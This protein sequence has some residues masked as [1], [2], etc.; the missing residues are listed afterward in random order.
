MAPSAYHFVNMQ[1]NQIRMTTAVVLSRSPKQL[2]NK[3]QDTRNGPLFRLSISIRRTNCEIIHNQPQRYN[4]FPSPNTLSSPFLLQRL[5][6][7]FDERQE[8]PSLHIRS[9]RFRD[10]QP[11]ENGMRPGLGWGLESTDLRCLVIFYDATQRSFGRAQGTIQHV[12]INLSR[13]VS[14]FQPTSDFESSALC[15]AIRELAE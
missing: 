12:D 3:R 7:F 6:K 9:K 8:V 13:L 2:I 1:P 11:L 10:D 4:P 14:R 15:D 5:G